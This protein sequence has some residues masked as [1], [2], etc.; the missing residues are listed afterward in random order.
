MS[1]DQAKDAYVEV[2]LAERRVGRVEDKECDSGKRETIMLLM[3]SAEQQREEA[4]D[5]ALR[6]AGVVSV[7]LCLLRPGFD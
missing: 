1:D 6:P 3:V 5:D 2:C 4:H 7:P